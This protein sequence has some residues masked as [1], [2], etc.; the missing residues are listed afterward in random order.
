MSAMNEITDYCELFVICSFVMC[1]ELWRR[2]LGRRTVAAVADRQLASLA[3]C[4]PLSMFSGHFR[5]NV[6]REGCHFPHHT[7][8]G[9]GWT[10][11]QRGG[12]CL[13]DVR[14]N[15][16]YTRRSATRQLVC[17]VSSRSRSRSHRL[18]R[19]QCKTYKFVRVPDWRVLVLQSL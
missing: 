9:A 5:R 17:E 14:L 3:W 4:A 7:T 10:N 13:H 16:S 15:K 11:R 2:V 8:N 12:Q 1:C 18:L 6:M 19:D